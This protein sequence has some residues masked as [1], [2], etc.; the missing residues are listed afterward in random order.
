MVRIGGRRP[1][2]QQQRQS[3]Q[4]FKIDLAG[5]VDI[6]NMDGASAATH[7]VAKTLF[8]DVV[9]VLTSHGFTAGHIPAKIEGLAFGPDVSKDNTKLH[10]LWV[11]NDNDFVLSTEDTPALPNSKPV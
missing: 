7:Q 8:L 6:S 9:A 10:T 1:F 4:L 5:A 3:Q 11:S 2:N